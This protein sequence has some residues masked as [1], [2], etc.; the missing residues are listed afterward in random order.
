MGYYKVTIHLISG[1]KF[2]GIREYQESPP[3]NLRMQIWD[4]ASQVPNRREIDHIDIV[5]L[6]PTDKEVVAQR[7]K[8]MGDF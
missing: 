1:K 5:P 2:E 7:L 8:D 4:K 3:Q 6:E